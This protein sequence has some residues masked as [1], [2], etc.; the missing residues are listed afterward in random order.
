VFKPLPI[1]V[2]FVGCQ[3]SARRLQ[4][5]EY[6]LDLYREHFANRQGDM[7]EVRDTGD[8]RPTAVAPHPAQMPLTEA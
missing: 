8:R 6:L 7:H 2:P 5:D 1:R 3:R 4:S